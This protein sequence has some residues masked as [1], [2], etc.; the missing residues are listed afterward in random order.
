MQTDL[1]GLGLPVRRSVPVPVGAV[2]ILA[3]LTRQPE[4][5]ALA[6]NEPSCYHIRELESDALA[7]LSVTLN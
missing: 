6:L 2:G 5:S 3:V 7:I 4:P 1:I